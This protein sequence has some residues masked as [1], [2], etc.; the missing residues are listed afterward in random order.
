MTD[1]FFYE[2]FAEEVEALRRYLDPDIPAQFS[3]QTIQ[4]RGDNS[5]P[6]SVISIRTQSVI[7]DA[8]TGALRAILS[9]STGYDH[10]LAYSQRTHTGAECGYLP[11][12]CHRAVAEQA[13]LLWTALLRKL[14]QQQRSFSSFHRDGL[15]GVELEG[16]TLLVVGVGNVGAEVCR[17]GQALGMRVVGVDVVEYQPNIEYLT[18]EQ[19]LPLA[20]VIVAAMNLTARNRGFFSYDVLRQ[21]KRGAVFIN[22]SRGEFSPSSVILRLLQ[23]GQLGGAALDV[24][25]GET[26]L[27]HAL[28][29]G[30][31]SNEPE[32]E[33]TMVLARMDNV[34]LTPHN[35]FNAREAVERKAEHS[36][37]QLCHL[38]QEGRFLWPIPDE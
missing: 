20:D 22:V 30:T 2:A 3:G 15:T 13:M 21:A 26:A 31:P 28:R 18:L 38:L 5:P 1:V 24:Y 36:A 8:W 25:A 35:A 10:L 29:S 11:R 33:A 19:A 12:Y 34:I 6:A 17:I 16:K 9:R 7:P 23:E 4:E 27:A 32:V 14:T 37:Q